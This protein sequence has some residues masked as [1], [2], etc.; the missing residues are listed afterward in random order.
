MGDGDLQDF[1]RWT[2]LSAKS[3][4]FAG[5]EILLRSDDHTDH[6]LNAPENEST[7]ELALAFNITTGS[8]CASSSSSGLLCACLSFHTPLLDMTCEK[9]I[10][11]INR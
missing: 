7:V 1:A 3:K 10:L 5:I 6:L 4:G 2:R 9:N 11:V 8:C